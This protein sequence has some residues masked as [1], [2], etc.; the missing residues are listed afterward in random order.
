MLVV[1]IVFGVGEA[2]AND[3][4]QEADDNGDGDEPQ[5]AERHHGDQAGDRDAEP[6]QSQ[7]GNQNKR[8]GIESHAGSSLRSGGDDSSPSAQGTA[9][10]RGGI[11]IEQSRA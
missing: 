6:E 10:S 4:C 7:T 9:V 2:L 8:E 5:K 1:I 11:G 3:R